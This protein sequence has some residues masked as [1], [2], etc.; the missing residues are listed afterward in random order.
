MN[1]HHMP[2]GQQYIHMKPTGTPPEVKQPMKK[3]T[4]IDPLPVTPPCSLLCARPTGYPLS[5]EFIGTYMVP[6]IQQT[7]II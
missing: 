3:E 1:K 5:D 6:D 2:V 7:G 4:V